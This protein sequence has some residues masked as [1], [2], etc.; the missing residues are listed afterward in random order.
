MLSARGYALAA[1]QVHAAAFA[2]DHVLRRPWTGRVI[3]V[4]APPVAL[5][6][7]VGKQQAKNQ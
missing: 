3:A 6:N 4:D 5:Q 7:P 2:A 1:R